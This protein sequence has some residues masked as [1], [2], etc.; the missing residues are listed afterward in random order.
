[1]TILLWIL[2]IGAWVTCGMLVLIVLKLDQL[3]EVLHSLVGLYAHVHNYTSPAP[4]SD[5]DGG[6]L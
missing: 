3:V 1:M 6:Q 5:Q 4:P 2:G